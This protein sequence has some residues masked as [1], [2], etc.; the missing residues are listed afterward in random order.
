M[1]ISLTALG[2]KALNT[3][4]GGL[5]SGLVGKALDFLGL[6]GD[7]GL[8]KGDQAELMRYQ[9]DLNME[10]WNEQ[11]STVS[12]Y[13]DPS[14]V[15]K[16]YM[17]AGINPASAF[18]KNTVGISSASQMNPVTGFPA[19]SRTQQVPNNAQYLSSIAQLMSA[20]SGANL[21]DAQANAINEKLFK[22]LRAM[23]DSHEWQ[24][25][26]NGLLSVYGDKKASAELQLALQNAQ[27]AGSESN[28]ANEQALTE[29]KKRLNI[30]MDTALKEVE[31]DL[32]GV[33]LKQAKI[34]LEYYRKFKDAELD[35]IFAD[36]QEKRSHSEN[37]VADTETKNIF[38]KFYS[39]ER[40]KH[41]F[42][43]QVVEQG[44]EA[45]SKRLV[46]ERQAKQLDYLVQ[47]A[48][49]ATDMQE[50]TYWSNQ[51][52]GFVNTL[53]QAASQFYGAGALRELI[54]LRQGQQKPALYSSD[55]Y[56]M[57]EGYLFKQK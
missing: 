7:D 22:E 35:N 52:N 14:Q 11:F 27:K 49:Y 23:D 50:F 21:S 37:L 39:D 38:N 57:Q 51:V 6:G 40:Y 36:S 47:Q 12:Q 32:S 43:S 25:L 41:S 10:A 44:R 34:D 56:Y 54:K 31:K 8:S 29:A 53:G 45:I 17:G 4:V 20:V 19:P 42:M 15:V 13:N 46:T 1:A 5:A 26:T 9:R 28:L 48:A 16:R 2:G 33:K 30:A 55:G 24:E 18:D 3:A